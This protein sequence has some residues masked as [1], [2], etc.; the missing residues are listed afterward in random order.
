MKNQKSVLLF[1][2]VFLGISG[3]F[4]QN[5]WITDH[6]MKFKI[7]AP[8]SYTTNQMRD[9]SDKVLTLMSPDQNVMIRVRAMPATEQFTPEVLQ[10][11]FEE[12]MIKGAQR[13][14]DENG[15]LNSIPA[16]SSAYTWSVDG[17]NAVLG[18]YY[19]VQQGF[20]YVVW[21]AVPRDLIQQ[22][23]AEADGIL[24][25]FTLE[26]PAVNSGGGVLGGLGSLGNSGATNMQNSSPVSTSSNKSSSPVSSN[27]LSLVS[28]D[29]CVEHFYPKGYKSTSVE[30]GQS[31]WEDGSG[32][33]MVVQT[34]IKTGNFRSYT[35]ENVASIANQGAD[36]VKKNYVSVNGYDVFQYFYT[37]GDTYF[38][39]FAVENNDVY[40]LVG[41][42]GNKLKQQKIVRYANDVLQS[43]RKVQCGQPAGNMNV[44]S[45]SET[46]SAT[47]SHHGF[48]FSTG[49]KGYADGETISW[50]PEGSN[51]NYPKGVWWRS[52]GKTQ[53]K[54]LGNVSLSSVSSVPN[55]WDNPA[56]PLLVGNTYV[57]K[58]TDGY[59]A[60]KVLSVNANANDWPVRVEYK[61]TTGSSF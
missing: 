49:K 17:S 55:S 14:L 28:D 50:C 45:V 22:R 42:V 15:E 34:I 5:G 53:Y 47:I 8:A 60:I 24:N 16:Q 11:V 39:Y 52:S 33:K 31:I 9:G 58:C 32:I 57:I 48:D 46:K 59:A 18:I 10:K 19:I 2:C 54:N 4:A 30:Q 20:A 23:S 51:P 40:Y 36:V 25:T 35:S 27:Y 21:T 12:N 1:L 29:A 7:K 26:Q 38:A 13:I 41:F 56:V 6:E 3:A 44:V 61:F 37:Y 43:V